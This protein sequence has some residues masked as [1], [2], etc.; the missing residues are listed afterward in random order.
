MEQRLKKRERNTFKK[1]D[2][3]YTLSLRDVEDL[4]AERGVAVLTRRFG[5]G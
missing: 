4:L 2:H 3:A 5:V 1:R